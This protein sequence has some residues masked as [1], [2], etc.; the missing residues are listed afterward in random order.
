VCVRFARSRIRAVTPQILGFASLA[1][2][3]SVSVPMRADATVIHAFGAALAGFF[4]VCSAAHL[5]AKGG[6]SFKRFSRSEPT[7]VTM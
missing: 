2:T 3:Q 6:R 1:L 7:G 4:F 5:A